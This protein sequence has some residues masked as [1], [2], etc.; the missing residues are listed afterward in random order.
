MERSKRVINMSKNDKTFKVFCD[1][2][3]EII[4]VRALNTDELEKYRQGVHKLV[5]SS[6][7]M[8]L[9]DY[10]IKVINDF[11]I[12]G[13]SLLSKCEQTIKEAYEED[14]DQVYAGIIESIYMSVCQV[15]PVLQLENIVQSINHET[16]KGFL[17]SFLEELYDKTDEKAPKRRARR[18]TRAGSTD[19]FTKNDEPFQ[20]I[21]ELPD[22]TR[23]ADLLQFLDGVSGN[24]LGAHSVLF[25][26][27]LIEIFCQHWN[28]FFS[29]IKGWNV[30]QDDADP[31]IKIFSETVFFNFFLDVFIGCR[32]DPYVDHD[33]LIASNP[34]NLVFLQSPEDFSLC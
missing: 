25:T 9:L 14:F 19:D 28:I 16:L 11:V 13:N 17:N 27:D 5:K 22:V 30:N 4:S 18:R 10:E 34:C 1:A 32:Y 8:D 29:L 24:G 12:N 23:P 15:Y 2:I 26:D 6:T 3:N 31:V 20:N 21:P 33:I 7:S